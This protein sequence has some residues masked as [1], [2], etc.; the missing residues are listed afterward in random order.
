MT[1]QLEDLKGSLAGDSAAR[2][3]PAL[4]LFGSVKFYLAGVLERGKERKQQKL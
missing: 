3:I 4:F 1:L 2:M